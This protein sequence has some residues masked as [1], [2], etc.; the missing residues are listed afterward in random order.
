MPLSRPLSTLLRLLGVL[1]KCSA[2]LMLILTVSDWLVRICVSMLVRWLVTL[3]I[4]VSRCALVGCIVVSL[5]LTMLC[6]CVIRLV[7]AMVNVGFGCRVLVL[8]IVNGAPNVRVRLRAVLCVCWIMLLRCVSR[9]P[10]R[11]ISGCIL[12]GMLLGLTC[13]CLL[14]LI[15]VSMVVTVCSGCRLQLIR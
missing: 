5:C 11:V 2:V 15:C 6:T 1:W 10:R 3:V 4:G 12:E 9:W 14:C 8:S 13:L 7:I